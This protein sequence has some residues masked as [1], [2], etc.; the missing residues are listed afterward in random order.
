MNLIGRRYG[1]IRVDR[2]LG[3]GGMGHVYEGFDEKLARRV[4]LKVL[5]HPSQRLDDEARTRLTR[6]ARTLGRL[7]HPNICRIYDFIDSD[8]A[9]VLVLELIDG[10][11]LQEALREGMPYSEKLRIAQD[12][13]KV[14]VVAHRAGIL[15]RDLKPENVMLTKTGDVKVLDFGLA[16]WLERERLVSSKHMAA[17]SPNELSAQLR[18]TDSDVER[19]D[20][21]DADADV[22]AIIRE[23]LGAEPLTAD[24]TAAGITVGTPLYMSPEQARG[25]SLTTATDLYSFG[26]LLQTLFTGNDPYPEG[27]TAREVMFR[28]ARG[29]T[30]P[31]V[32]APHAVTTLIKSLKAFAPAD[33][34]T[35]GDTLRRIRYIA[36]TPKRYARRTAIALLIAAA[37]F[38]IWKYTIDLRRERAAAQQAEAEARRRRAQADSL[39]GFMLGDLRQ[40]LEPVGR[41]DI[42]DGVA[43]RSLAYMSSLRTEYMSP[44][45]IARNS[46]ALYQLGEVRI[47]QGRLRDATAVLNRSLSL[48]NEAARRESTN[49]TLQL[50]L[51]TAHFWVGNAAQLSGDLAGALVHYRA[52]LDISER[53]SHLPPS[54]AT[55][56]LER[57]YGHGNVGTILEQ[58]GHLA[59]ALDHYDTALAL[60][61]QRLSENPADSQLQ[62]DLALTINKIGYA[63]YKLGDLASARRHFDDE[64][65]AWKELV[66]ID[67]KQARWKERLAI[68]YAFLGRVLIDTGETDGAMTALN[69]ELDIERSLVALDATN[70]VWARNLAYTTVNIADLWRSIGKPVDSLPLFESAESAYVDLLKR[71]PTRAVWK[72]DLAW[73]RARQ[74][75]ALEA[76]GRLPEAEARVRAATAVFDDLPQNDRFVRVYRASAYVFAGEIAAKRGEDASRDWSR[77]ESLLAADPRTTDIA[78]LE[79][80]LRLALNTSQRGS[81]HELA[82]RLQTMGDKSPDFVTLCH[83]GC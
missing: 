45:E 37:V 62:A 29:D 69:A 5:H 36:D 64:V 2:M 14:M 23:K 8:D 60:K 3:Q 67:P 61:R 27:L 71:D 19:W 41:L 7:D 30:L 76:L 28:A 12:I 51:G 49:E 11:T 42:L 65:A 18:V 13:A 46:K 15:H 78:M 32:G 34:P 55:Y 10:R 66:G 50:E 39:I 58:Q 17:V 4:A 82:A 54:S 79:A 1:H 26:L 16:R 35:A 59:E 80:R 81:A 47:A 73:A 72:R 48:A 33:R 57:A 68:A 75:R 21:L 38:G 44:E 83:E 56:Q 52:Y 25:E 74:A 77:A 6:E 24:A 63:R 43:A 70:T 20:A 22:T 40:K 9:D 31:V 53:L